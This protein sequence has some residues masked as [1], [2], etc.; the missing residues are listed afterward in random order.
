M[1]EGEVVGSEAVVSGCEAAAMF[2]FVEAA[3]DA[4]S[5]FV[6]GGVVGDRRFA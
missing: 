6:D 2:E 1:D 4:V 5:E 3:L